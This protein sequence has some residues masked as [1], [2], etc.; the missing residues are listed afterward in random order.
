MSKNE[1]TFIY[2]IQNDILYLI[3]DHLRSVRLKYIKSNN[4]V[5]TI[6]YFNKYNPPI[7]IFSI[8]Q[9]SFYK[10]DLL[11]DL[12]HQNYELIILKDVKQQ[13]QLIDEID[14]HPIIYTR[15]HQKGLRAS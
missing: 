7:A 8:T 12:N 14:L 6:Y 13:N 3:K 9:D 11:Q 15:V 1:I 4:F 2:L 5:S 10:K